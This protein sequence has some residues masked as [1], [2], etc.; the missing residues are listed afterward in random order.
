MDETDRKILRELKR[1]ASLSQREV[2]ERVSLSQ[3]ACWARLRKLH[4]SGVITG[5]TINLDPRKI[6]IG[7]TV[8]MLIKTR[9]HSSE[10]LDAFTRRLEADEEVVEFFRIAGDFDYVLKIMTRDVSSFDTVYKRLIAGSDFE[11]VTSYVVMGDVKKQ[12][13]PPLLH[14]S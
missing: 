12:S 2:A 11:T 1:D 4:E 13:G 7:I 9:H 14:C 6:G 10:W 5:T 8:L 3:N